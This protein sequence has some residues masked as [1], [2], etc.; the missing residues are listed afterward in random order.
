MKGKEPPF[1]DR[2]CRGAVSHLRV[3]GLQ[4]SRDQ[5]ARFCRSGR[6]PGAVMGLGGGAFWWAN[7]QRVTLGSGRESPWTGACGG[8]DSVGPSISPTPGL[9]RRTDGGLTAGRRRAEC[10]HHQLLAPSLEARCVQF[11]LPAFHAS[12]VSAVTVTSPPF[13]SERHIPQSCHTRGLVL[14]THIPG[15]KEP[16]I[17]RSGNRGSERLSDVPKVTQL[18]GGRVRAG[19]PSPSLDRA[20]WESTKGRP[21]SL[22]ARGADRETEAEQTEGSHRLSPSSVFREKGMLGCL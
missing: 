2:H 16:L 21:Q 14:S 8:S 6:A 1:L 20:P 19:N 22:L 3:P 11:N 13:C 10:L 15:S 7:T 4:G 18:T 12:H 5:E 9:C 17:L